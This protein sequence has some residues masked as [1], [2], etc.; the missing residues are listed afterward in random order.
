MCLCEEEE[1]SC[2]IVNIGIDDLKNRYTTI[3]KRE[4]ITGLSPSAY[5]PCREETSL[6]EK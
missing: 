3:L 1:W 2:Q 5:A 6:S 4:C